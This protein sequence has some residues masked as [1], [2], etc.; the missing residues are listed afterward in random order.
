MR[1]RTAL[2]L[3]LIS[4]CFLTACNSQKNV[5]G[6]VTE[7]KIDKEIGVTSFVVRTEM[8]K[9]IGFFI[10]D[11]T[12]VF[13]FT[14]DVIVDD[15]KNGSFVN[16]MVSVERKNLRHSLTTKNNQNITAYNAE[17]IQITGFLTEETA[18][19]SDG[20]RLDIWNYL[21]DCLYTLQNGTE[22]MRVS[23]VTGPNNVYVGGIESFDNLGPAAQSNIL[24]FYE[25]QGLLYD[26][27]DELE[28]AYDAY[29]KKEDPSQ[30]NGY[31]ISQDIAPTASNEHMMYFLTSV[32]LPIDHNQYNEYRIGAAFDRKTGEEISDWDL[33]SYS[34]EEAKQAVLEIAGI[35]DPILKKEMEI[36][37]KPECLIWFPDHLE[38]CFN[39]GTLPSQEGVYM[40]GLDYD[41]KLS[42][43][44]N[45]WAIPKSRE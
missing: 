3:L 12:D 7:V 1:K 20:T 21:D 24:K 45:E 19:L 10:T 43:I 22:L 13:S 35:S 11:K 34:P 30:F 5:F 41:D 8:D 15:F 26:I 44:I 27:Q 39:Q 40:L 4:L 33:F 9:E 29:L 32:L 25:E 31:M 14:P 16:V 28:K 17:Q 37:L 42:E 36:A 38:V 18:T 23:N 6:T 2:I